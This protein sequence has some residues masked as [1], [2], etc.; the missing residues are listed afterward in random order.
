LY[1]DDP[2][3]VYLREVCTV[4][5]L[6]REEEIE[7][8]RHTLAHDQRAESARKRLIEANLALVVSIAQNHGDSGVHVL[9]L[10]IAGNDGIILAV[11]TYSGESPKSF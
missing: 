5:A 3:A 1:D 2:V 8:L 11:K 10:I 7:L 9:D 4:P 6:T